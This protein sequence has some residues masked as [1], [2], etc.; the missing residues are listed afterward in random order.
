[1]EELRNTKHSFLAEGICCCGSQNSA[2][3]Q[4]DQCVFLPSK[5]RGEGRGGEEKGRGEGREGEGRSEGRSFCHHFLIISAGPLHFSITAVI[6]PAGALR[7]C[8][9]SFGSLVLL[10]RGGQTERYSINSESRRQLH[11]DMRNK[12]RQRQG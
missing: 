10:G 11:R 12:G 9:I 3:S 4:P 2:C 5:E 7:S 8:L 6:I 1:M